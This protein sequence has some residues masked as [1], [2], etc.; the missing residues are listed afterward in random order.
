MG[1]TTLVR[2][3]AASLDQQ[4]VAGFYTE[5]IRQRGA[6]VGFQ[7]TTFDG[8]NRLMAH[9]AFPK[10]HRVGR[11]GVD[12][13]AIDAAVDSALAPE[14]GANVFLV[15][16]IGKMECLSDLFLE[17]VRRLLETPVPFLATVARRGSGLIAEV[18]ER[19][20]IEL[21]EVTRENRDRLPRELADRLGLTPRPPADPADRRSR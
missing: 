9:V 10:T 17:A 12:V 18:K 15:D 11:Y 21:L 5:E 6:R 13:A 3:I 8:T 20:D 2:R 1:K 4:R 19:G 16:E 7:L 14:G